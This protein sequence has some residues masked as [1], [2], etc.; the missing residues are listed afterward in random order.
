MENYD[1]KDKSLAEG[2]RR[3]IK[4]AEREMPVLRSIHER[5]IKERPFDGIRMSACLHVTTET[6]NLM[7]TLQAGGA[8]VVLVDSEKLL[9]LKVRAFQVHV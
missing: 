7:K 9:L 6:A 5:F 3:R 4:W 2:G 1:I 8:D